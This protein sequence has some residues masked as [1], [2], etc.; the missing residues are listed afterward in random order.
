MADTGA[1]PKKKPVASGGAGHPCPSPYLHGPEGGFREPTDRGK[2]GWGRA[3]K[4]CQPSSSSSSTSR[5]RASSSERVVTPKRLRILAMW[6]SAV[7][8][9]MKIALP[10]SV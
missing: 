7:R 3:A 8:G 5:R 4:A 10:I 2:G 6:C 9:E 1:G